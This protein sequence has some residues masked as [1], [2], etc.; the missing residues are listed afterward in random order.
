MPIIGAY[1]NDTHEWV[2]IDNKPVGFFSNLDAVTY[3]MTRFGSTRAELY[4]TTAFTPDERLQFFRDLVPEEVDAD[5]GAAATDQPEEVTLPTDGDLKSSVA[6]LLLGLACAAAAMMALYQAS[7]LQM[8]ACL[9]GVLA[10]GWLSGVISVV[11][12]YCGIQAER[13]L[14]NK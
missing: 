10:M 11:S 5:P 9:S 4:T 13:R 2:C 3:L 1:H 6:W 7:L 14:P 12:V 8:T